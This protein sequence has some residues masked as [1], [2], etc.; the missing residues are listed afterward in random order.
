MFSFRFQIKIERRDFD[1]ESCTAMFITQCAQW[2]RRKRFELT[3]AARLNFVFAASI[4]V[5]SFIFM[6][7]SLP[8]MDLCLFHAATSL[9]C[10]GCGMTRAFCA[11]SHGQFAVAW[12]LNPFSFHL[13]A[14]SV[15]GSIYP[16]FANSIPEKL[17]RAAALI[18]IAALIIFGVFRIL[19]NLNPT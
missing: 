3:P 1:L 8:K 11:I 7:D 9:Q 14:L 6:P 15:L 5:L 10:P 13:Y 4:L 2:V 16:L 19:M 17:V 18:T 12:Q